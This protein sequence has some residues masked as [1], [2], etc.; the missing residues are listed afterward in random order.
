LWV[1]W[2]RRSL[3]P[4][5]QGSEGLPCDPS[6]SRWMDSPAMHELPPLLRALLRWLQCRRKGLPG[7]ICPRWCRIQRER[8]LASI[9]LVIRLTVSGEI[10]PFWRST[11]VHKTRL[12]RRQRDHGSGGRVVDLGSIRPTCGVGG[13]LTLLVAFALWWDGESR[14]I[15]R[16][17]AAARAAVFTVSLDYCRTPLRLR[18]LC[19]DWH[20]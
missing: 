1:G 17:F 8:Y 10:A 12:R 14:Q 6:S 5:S 19:R 15:R 7:E 20:L 16:E 2:S 3:L 9:L 18:G 11:G 4:E 13:T